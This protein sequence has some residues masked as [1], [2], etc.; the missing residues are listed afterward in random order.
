M[1]DIMYE[2]P[3]RR[4]KGKCLVTAE[5]VRSQ[6]SPHVNFPAESEPE[7]NEASSPKAAVQKRRAG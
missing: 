1:L 4:S 3:S 7:E 6:Q 2:I 5:A